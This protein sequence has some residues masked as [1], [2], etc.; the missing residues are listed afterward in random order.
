MSTT[1]SFRGMLQSLQTKLQLGHD[2]AL[3]H[4]FQSITCQSLY[5]ST[6]HNVSY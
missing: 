6:L 1:L 5:Q 3:P 2:R 4:P